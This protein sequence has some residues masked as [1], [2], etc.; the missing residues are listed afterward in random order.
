MQ[1]QSSSSTTTVEA[2]VF[3][4]APRVGPLGVVG[5]LFLFLAFTLG[6]SAEPM[7]AAAL[8]FVGWL[9][10]FA[11]DLRPTRR[12]RRTRVLCKP[13]TLKVAG[14]STIR[15]RDLVGA[16]TAHHEGGVSLMLAHRRRR[17]RPIVL[18]L[19][20]ESALAKVC[21]ALGIGHH[22]F[23]FVDVAVEPPPYAWL[24]LLCAAALLPVPLV[25]LAIDDHPEVV[26]AFG[27]LGFMAWIALVVGTLSNAAMVMRLTGSGA[28]FPRWRRNAGYVGFAAMESVQR[29]R[30]GLLVTAREPDGGS[31]AVPV[32]FRTSS[33]NR[34]SPT[35]HE[36]AHVESQLRA[37]VE[38]A[39]GKGAPERA[40]AAFA[41]VI[42]R[43]PGEPLR[44]WLARVDTIAV[45]APGYRS[46]ASAS[47]EELWS[48]LEDPDASPNARAAAARLLSRVAPDELRV[49]VGDVLSTVRDERARVRI[50]AS[51]DED[52]LHEEEQLELAERIKPAV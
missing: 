20:D 10:L 37:A 24:R 42:E 45:G 49:R 4:L 48:L 46:S 36:V 29:N 32:R 52:A 31:A 13:G 25:V 28:F 17:N 21:R 33:L 19:P 14:G 41:A 1:D 2:N 40:L 12:P 47:R 22:G 15:A 30:D 39:H 26:T 27:F 6:Q 34:F 7:H 8:A 43:A 3:D 11:Y 38:R 9:A 23:G 51:Y 50:A 44:D 35:T 5:P 16:T 18:D